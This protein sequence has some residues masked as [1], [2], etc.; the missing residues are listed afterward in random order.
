MKIVK[1]RNYKM[2]HDR[3][4]PNGYHYYAF[5]WNDTRNKW[6][7][8]QLTHIANKDERRYRQTD[9]GLIKPI[10]IPFLDKYADSGVTRY[11]YIGDINNDNLDPSMGVIIGDVNVDIAN[12]ILNHHN[13]NVTR[14]VAI[15]SM[16]RYR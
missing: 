4:N 14:G 13:I 11:N 5:Y 6:N 8:V 3:I 12:K 10:R 9:M 1:V 15:R 7:A 2:Y 16:N